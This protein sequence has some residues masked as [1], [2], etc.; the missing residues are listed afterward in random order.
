[1]MRN[2]WFP[3]RMG[4][5]TSLRENKMKCP[6]C[7]TELIE[8]EKREYQN[9]MEH[10]VN[11]NAEHYPLKE[12]WV[13]PN[14]SCRYHGDSFWDFFGDFYTSDPNYADRR[15]VITSAIGSTSRRLE[16]EN[17]IARKSQWFIKIICR[18]QWFSRS[19]FLAAWLIR[20]NILFGEE[21]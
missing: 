17:K 4:L 11:P 20:R 13:C 2:L 19:H 6:F 9:T 8:G 14:E 3:I 12:T 18:K 16:V 1:M 10:V 5:D 7:K 15:N 21:L